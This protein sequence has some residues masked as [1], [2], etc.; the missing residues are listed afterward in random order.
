MSFNNVQDVNEWIA[1]PEARQLEQDI[2]RGIHEALKLRDAMTVWLI[3]DLH[4]KDISQGDPEGF[5]LESVNERLEAWRKVSRLELEQ[6]Q[7]TLQELKRDFFDVAGVEY[8]DLK[9]TEAFHEQLRN[10]PADIPVD[11]DSLHAYLRRCNEL[12]YAIERLENRGGV[13]P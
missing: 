7:A 13:V 11:L 3:V 4:A 2:I 6:R 5:A 12:Y 1:S 9:I 10:I 8:D